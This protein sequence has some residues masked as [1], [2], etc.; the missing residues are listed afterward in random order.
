MLKNYNFIK[1][2]IINKLKY[3]QYIPTIKNI[4]INYK[5]Y[6]AFL[7]GQF[8]L[9]FSS[10]NNSNDLECWL[11]LLTIFTHGNIPIKISI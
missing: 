3:K 7:L 9:A 11:Q 6:N 1:Y 10:S 4:N 2:L 8:I 5:Y